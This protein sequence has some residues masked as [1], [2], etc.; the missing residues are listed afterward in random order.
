LQDGRIHIDKINYPFVDH[1]KAKPSEYGARP[2]LAIER[3]W[4]KASETARLRAAG[5]VSL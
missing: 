3:G 4:L 2:K 5:A 1:E